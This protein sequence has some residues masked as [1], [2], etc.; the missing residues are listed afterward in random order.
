MKD[1]EVFA[2]RLAIAALFAAA[3]ISK[4]DEGYDR[5]HLVQEALQTAAELMK[6]IG[7]FP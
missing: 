3:K 2:V 6:Q 1:D 4:V 5:E 7:P